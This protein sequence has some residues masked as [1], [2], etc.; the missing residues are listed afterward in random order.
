MLT[1]GWISAGFMDIPKFWKSVKLYTEDLV[2]EEQYITCEY[3]ED[4]GMLENCTHWHEVVEVF[5][6]SSFQEV[7]L[8]NDYDV[9][10]R[11]IRFRFKLHTKDNTKTPVIKAIIVEALLRFPVRF[12]YSFNFRL[13]DSPSNYTGDHD[14][15]VR[16]EDVAATLD[17]WGNEPTVLTM[18]CNFSPFDNKRVV[19]EPT[20]LK[21]IELTNDN[22]LF[23]KHIGQ[24]TLLEV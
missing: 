8:S 19:I 5:N 18:R 1:T 3:Q 7:L 11:Q 2:D 6:T 21:P 10:A 16:A 12:S 20:S 24:I 23:E 4:Y 17:T 22:V 15:T 14:H 13:E 9:V